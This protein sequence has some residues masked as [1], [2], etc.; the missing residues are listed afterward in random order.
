VFNS[1]RFEKDTD[2]RALF[3]RLGVDDDG[4]HAFYLGREL[5]KADIARRLGKKYI[6]GEPLHW[7]YLTWTEAE[8]G[9]HARRPARR[10]R[11]ATARAG[12]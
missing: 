7:G 8:A 2:I 11:A 4:S 12:R 6:Q 9:D 5:M 3:P 10:R 1:E